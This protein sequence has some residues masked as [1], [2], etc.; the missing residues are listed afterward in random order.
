MRWTLVFLMA[1]ALSL[2]AANRKNLEI[3]FIDTEGGQATLLVTPSGESLL[4]D[5]GFPGNNGRDSDRIVAAAK[6]AGLTKI[7]YLL[8][9]H[10][11]LDHVG[12]VPELAA[13]F[14]VGTLIDHGANV[15]TGRGADTLNAAYQKVIASGAKRLTVK[16]GDILPLK[17]LRIEVITANG[18]RI[19]KPV[20][21]G[22]Q[23]NPVCGTEQRRA[24]DPS[25]NA[26]SIGVLMTFGK[27]RFVDLGDLTW[28]KEL[29]AA[30]PD[31]L[32]GPVDL[33]L[34]T[35]HGLDQSNSASMV[36]GLHPRVAIMNN[37]AKKGGSPAAWS[38][39]SAS[40]GLQDLWQIHY[41]EAGGKDHN[42][43]EER[44]ANPQVPCQGAGI[45]VAAGKDGVF[46]VTNQR[47][48][49]KKTY[50]P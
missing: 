23:K 18:E 1:G 25:E 19:P 39:V 24:D 20:K 47:N 50:K 10:Y 45:E 43:A 37:G 41:A 32:I 27:F 17:D 40:P 36:H 42:V 5:A 3:T 44:I 49:L 11:H 30:C 14:P 21:G 6:K 31:H 13:K 22:G 35:H 28:N 2:P 7:D 34:T 12:G 46:T 16:P 33:F 38:I 48:G 9:T 4:V 8:V 29:D 26:R 15:E